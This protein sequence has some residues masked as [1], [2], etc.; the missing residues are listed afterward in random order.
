MPR[1]A[2]GF[3]ARGAL[4]RNLRINYYRFAHAMN[5]PGAD[6]PSYSQAVVHSHPVF[7]TQIHKYPLPTVPVLGCLWLLG[8]LKT[9]NCRPLL[10]QSPPASS[11]VLWRI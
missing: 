4:G 5:R 1:A 8:G 7:G 10:Q 2:P 3:N 11:L 9:V 6:V